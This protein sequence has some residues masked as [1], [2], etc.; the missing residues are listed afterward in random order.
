MH[1]IRPRA[2]RTALKFG[3]EDRFP[4]SIGRLVGFGVNV[5]FGAVGVICVV[6]RIK[7]VGESP[8]RFFRDIRC[9]LNRPFRSVNSGDYDFLGE[10]LL[11][12]R[13]FIASREPKRL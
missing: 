1:S 12:S 6:L 2:A 3:V 13:R 9:R 4:Y 5:R 7:T 8:W 11:P 10:F